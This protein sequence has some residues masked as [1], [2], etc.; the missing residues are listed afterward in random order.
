MRK[1]VL[2]VLVL[3][4][5]SHPLLLLLPPLLLHQLRYVRGQA[6]PLSRYPLNKRG[7]VGI[8]P[9]Y[10]HEIRPR[11]VALSWI[12][13]CHYAPTSHL[14]RPFGAKGYRDAQP[15]WIDYIT[16]DYYGAVCG[17]EC[18]VIVHPATGVVVVVVHGNRVTTTTSSSASARFIN[19]YP[20]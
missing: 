13:M 19:R 12:G 9:W 8:H 10:L 1:L 6:T 4:L 16:P 7:R 18:A 14:P 20:L 17:L 5:K 3:L 11:L 15:E 2:L